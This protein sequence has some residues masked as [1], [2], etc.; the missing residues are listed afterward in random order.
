MS[1]VKAGMCKVVIS[2]QLCVPTLL[3]NFLKLGNFAIRLRGNL[4][5]ET[6]LSTWFMVT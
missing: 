4:N 5:S 1:E 6:V 2:L 3:S